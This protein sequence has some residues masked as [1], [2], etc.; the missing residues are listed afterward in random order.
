MAWIRHWPLLWKPKLDMSINCSDQR[1]IT[2]VE[3]I[4][5]ILIVAI[6]VVGLVS[7]MVP[8]IQQSANPLA[9]KQQASIAES[10]LNEVLDQPF[11]WCDPDDDGAISAMEYGACVHP[12]TTGTGEL[13][14]GVGP[15]T[16]F[17]NVADYNNYAMNDVADA[18]GN[19]A[20][21]GYRVD[22][23]V[24]PAG[25]IMG[26]A[27]NSAVLRVTVTVTH[28]ADVFALSGFRFRYA[29]RT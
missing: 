27:D 28:G 14:Y 4:V 13:R 26:I 10:L 7:L 8:M 11:T 25:N 15:G 21:P 23:T 29:P 2:L 3:Q 9:I 20:M 22:V 6:G 17:D 1:G 24:E 16:A 12:Q 5:F 18:A 19:N